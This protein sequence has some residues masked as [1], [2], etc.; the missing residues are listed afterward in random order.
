MTAL[1]QQLRWSIERENLKLALK[2]LLPLARKEYKA[3]AEPS[4]T[5]CAPVGQAM[6]AEAK[7]WAE[8]ILA[9]EKALKP[10]EVPVAEPIPPR[11]CDVCWDATPGTINGM[12]LTCY[13]LFHVAIDCGLRHCI[14][15]VDGEP[16]STEIS[17]LRVIRAPRRPQ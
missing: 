6:R 1:E 17:N 7:A 2:L 11:T 4:T 15:H 16:R 13:E 3:V 10:V 12:C 9:A 8:A 5:C 14:D